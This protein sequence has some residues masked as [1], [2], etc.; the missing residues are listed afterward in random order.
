MLKARV[1][2]AVMLKEHTIRVR[3]SELYKST[4]RNNVSYTRA[5]SAYGLICK[6]YRG[7]ISVDVLLEHGHPNIERC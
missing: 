2:S 7:V 5:I 4:V 1:V 3:Q 6:A